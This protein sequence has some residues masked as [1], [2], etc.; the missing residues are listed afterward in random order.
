M[1]H[2]SVFPVMSLSAP[3]VVNFAH[4]AVHCAIVGNCAFSPVQCV[5]ISLQ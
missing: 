2:P 3:G 5:S 4:V 1:R